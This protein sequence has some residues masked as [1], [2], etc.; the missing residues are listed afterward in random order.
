MSESLNS[1]PAL[2]LAT[3]VLEGVR[4]E[5]ER[6][7]FAASNFLS[8]VQILYGEKG[9][10]TEELDAGRMAIL[11]PIIEPSLEL[12]AEGVIVNARLIALL[13]PKIWT[14]P[15]LFDPR[16]VRKEVYRSV[17]PATRRTISTLFQM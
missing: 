2:S 6:S 1:Q 10:V 5:D 4:A 8:T 11:T 7:L 13:N 16:L 12:V 9:F 3:E 17:F 15:S 14:D